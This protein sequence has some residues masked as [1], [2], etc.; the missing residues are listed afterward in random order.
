MRWK[1][2]SER[3]SRAK[4]KGRRGSTAG[5]GAQ[6]RPRAGNSPTTTYPLR[7]RSSTTLS[8]KELTAIL[9]NVEVFRSWLSSI[10]QEASRR[11][12]QGE[13]IT[14][15]KLVLSQKNR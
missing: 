11:L 1:M 12:F 9:L 7:L 15:K 10:E 6:Q 2:P 3:T 8:D 13:S 14:G 4:G 5:T